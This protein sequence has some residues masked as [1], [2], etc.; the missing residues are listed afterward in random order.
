M[1]NNPKIV[2]MPWKDIKPY[3]KNPRKNGDAVD[4]V[5]NSIREFGFRQPI[6]VDRNHVIIAGHTRWKASARLK[7]KEV[8]VLI[9]ED[10]T[11]DQVRAYRIADNSTAAL[12]EWD[13][14]LLDTELLDIGYDMSDFGLDFVQIG[15]SSDPG[16]TEEV[17]VPDVP[18]ET[19]VKRGQ[20]YELGDHRLMC[21]DSTDSDDVDRLV[22]GGGYGSRCD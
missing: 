7:L 2:M 22:G 13:L 20:I 4:A 11:D 8:P 15:E 3:D 19:Y 9:A 21:G 17:D 6:V 18:E 5:A 1:T 10:L 12:A 16:D 14:D